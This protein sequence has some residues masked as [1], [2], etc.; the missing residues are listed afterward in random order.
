MIS[1]NILTVQKLLYMIEDTPWASKGSE[2]ILY[3]ACRLGLVSMVELAI[4]SPN[5]D[6]TRGSVF[7]RET[8]LLHVAA[9]R[10]NP[11]ILQYLLKQ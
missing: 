10:R 2:Y 3:Q 6:S 1:G 9:S 4:S 11:N 7:P 8:P 5:F